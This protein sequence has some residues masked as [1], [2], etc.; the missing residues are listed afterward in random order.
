MKGG[1]DSVSQKGKSLL[2]KP[3]GEAWVIYTSGI[4]I[5]DRL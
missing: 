1:E 3:V 5:Q 4:S 2:G